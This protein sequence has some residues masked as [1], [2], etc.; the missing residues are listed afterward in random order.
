MG[1]RHVTHLLVRYVHGQLRPAQR[2]WV[3][4]H[5]R[6]CAR[7]RAALAREERLA[8]DLRRE[9]PSL[10]Q[11]RPA[12]LAKVWAG[13]WQD[14]NTPRPRS[15]ASGWTLLPGLS[16]ALVIVLVVMVALPLVAQR[17]VRAEAAPFQA[18]PET[19]QPASPAPAV[20]E[21]APVQSVAAQ[22]QPQ[23]TVAY[24]I[25]A[26]ASPAPIP[27]QTVSPAVPVGRQ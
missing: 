10:G 22:G 25:P 20:T 17:D 27:R 13:V 16:M 2:A 5:V 7:C 26:G 19:Q 8:G 1:K 14:V 24:A 21:E 4:N 12:Q 11:P 18:R 3:I 15:R 23:A 6:T 9:V